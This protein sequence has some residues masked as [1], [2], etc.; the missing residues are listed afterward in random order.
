MKN[1][2]KLKREIFRREGHLNFSNNLLE[3]PK[4][5]ALQLSGSLSDNLSDP[6]NACNNNAC[7]GSNNPNNSGCTNTTCV[8]TEMGNTSCT[9]AECC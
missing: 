4:I 7:N 5:V 9:N 6:N 3:I 1:I 8:A 2:E